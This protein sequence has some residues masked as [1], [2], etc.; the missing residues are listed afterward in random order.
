MFK[1]AP[2]FWAIFGVGAINFL[3][4]SIDCDIIHFIIPYAAYPDTLY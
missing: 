4:V 1:I 3:S 2:K